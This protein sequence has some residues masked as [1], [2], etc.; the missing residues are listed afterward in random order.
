M[1]KSWFIW[2]ELSSDGNEDIKLGWKVT[3]FLD[4][5][6]IHSCVIRSDLPI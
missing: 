4:V 3:I 6:S 5:L 1:C 2:P